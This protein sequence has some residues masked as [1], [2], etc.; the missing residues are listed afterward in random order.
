MD[1]RF[2]KINYIQDVQC[3]SWCDVLVFN[4]GEGTI[5]LYVLPLS[6]LM[7]F[8]SGKTIVTVT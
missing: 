6:L 5:K 8:L 7:S 1:T 4:R 3:T 2:S